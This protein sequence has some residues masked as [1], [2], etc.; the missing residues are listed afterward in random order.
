MNKIAR[1]TALIIFPV[2]IFWLGVNIGVMQGRSLDNGIKVQNMTGTTLSIPTIS[3]PQTNTNG[4]EFATFWEVW[5]RLKKA[6]PNGVEVSDTTLM[7][8]AIKGLANSL[9]DP[10][11]YYLTPEESD[12]FIHTDLNGEVSGIGAELK[13]GEGGVL[14]VVSV[15][16]ESPAKKA[17]VL[18]GDIIY[19][20]NGEVQ[21]NVSLYEAVKKIRGPKGT[22]VTLTIVRKDEDETLEYK[23]MRDDIKVPSVN[24]ETREGGNVGYIQLNKFS[25]STAAELQAVAQKV[26]LTPPKSLVLDLRD[27]SGGYLDA[28]VDVVSIFSERGVVVTMKEA[29]KEP[30]VYNVNGRARLTAFPM[31]VLINEQSASAAEIVAGA[32]KESGRA[33]LI[34]KHTYGKGSVQQLET[35]ADGSSLRIT[36]AKWFTPSGFNVMTE[37][38]GEPGLHP[39]MKVELTTA[40]RKEN[41]DPQMEAAIT[42]LKEKVQW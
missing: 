23:I 26:L 19:K 11:T 37:T 2:L 36:I 34:G 15:I 7:Q 39:D 42:Y 25:E 16:A 35:L 40:D 38:E 21:S 13:E 29:D 5:Q 8:G 32:L 10:Y 1:N 17:G 14:T 12:E 9:E 30:K 33:Y 6:H 22:E 24:Y 27:N 3:R 18:P 31:I 41:R 4:V 20:V 28:A